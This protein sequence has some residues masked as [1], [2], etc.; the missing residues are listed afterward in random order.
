MR[1]VQEVLGE[2]EE[3]GIGI[4]GVVEKGL[5]KASR[6][7]GRQTCMLM[8]A[9]KIAVVVVVEDMQQ[10]LVLALPSTDII[11]LYQLNQMDLIL[12]S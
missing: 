12:Q 2:E 6:N 10:G 11:L 1:L 8:M 3:E 4:V 7:N 9:E 5:G